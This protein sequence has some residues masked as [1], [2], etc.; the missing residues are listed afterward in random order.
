M[1]RLRKFLLRGWN[2]SIGQLTKL[3]MQLSKLDYT[4]LKQLKDQLNGV[5][6]QY[7]DRLICLLENEKDITED[8]IINL[9]DEL[10]Q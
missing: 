4:D 6:V 3:S 7:I 1:F 8:R 2:I 10:F 5:D 9:I